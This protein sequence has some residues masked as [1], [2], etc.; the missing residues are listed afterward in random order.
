[1]V[2]ASTANAGSIR[3]KNGQFGQFIGRFLIYAFLIVL[4][5]TCLIPFYSMIIDSTH[6]SIA[7]STSLQLLPGAHF[8]ANY[9]RLMGIIN[10]WQGFLHSLYIA[11]F[12][13]S[14]TLYFSALAGY[15]FSKYAFKGK[16]VLFAFIISTMMIPGQLGIIG[17]F[18]LME[19]MHMLNTYWPM[20]VP[21]IASA[22]AIFF[23]RQMCSSSVP[24]ELL[25]AARI[26]GAGE[27]RIFHRIVL[28]LL[29]PALATMGIFTF[30]GNW[31]GFFL[32]LIVIFDDSK[33]TLPVM[34]ALTKGQFATDYGAQYVGVVISV[35][36]IVI[37]FAILS[38]RI[39]GGITV[40]ALKG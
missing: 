37:V 7:I 14:L 19:R 32:P 1:M 21:A 35:I 27:L 2:K 30:I 38:R 28:P 3:G 11:L 10:I 13:T 40:G 33:Q 5:L 24:D 6:G 29:A 4:A 39:I 16:G 18:V 8:M 26:D 34:V 12:A 15:G 36:P 9:Q 23:F 20:I 17:F 25:D 22:F 31:N